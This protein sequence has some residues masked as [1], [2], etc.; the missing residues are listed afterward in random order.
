M[1]CSRCT[2]GCTGAC[3]PGCT[4]ECGN[5]CRGGCGGCSYGCTGSC[6]SCSGCSGCTGC[7]SCS[8]CSNTC[9]AT[10][11]DNCNNNC[12]TTCTG[13][14]TNTCKNYCNKGC[15]GSAMNLTLD[16]YFTSE[17]AQAIADAI[18]FEIGRRPNASTPVSTTNLFT[19]GKVLTATDI[20]KLITNLSKVGKTVTSA[21]Q[22]TTAERT[23]G[24][25]IIAKL[26]EANGENIP[27]A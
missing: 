14:C 1:A 21:T 6:T 7:T 12:K 2:Y 9:T 19:D 3:A 20:N 24:E 16:T 4:G 10:C 17:N 13:A 8:G 27:I 15:S 25:S 26:L 23:L 5:G 22:G 18:I 11:A